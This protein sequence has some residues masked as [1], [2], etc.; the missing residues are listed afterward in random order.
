M[1][2]KKRDK[3]LNP[4]STKGDRVIEMEST[5]TRLKTSLNELCD[6]ILLTPG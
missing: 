2:E 1:V 4:K 3:N 5:L 6:L